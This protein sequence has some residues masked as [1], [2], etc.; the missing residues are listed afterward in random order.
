MAKKAVTSQREKLIERQNNG[1]FMVT[2]FTS[3]TSRDWLWTKRG[4]KV[5]DKIRAIQALSCSLPTKVNKTRGNP[6]LTVKRCKT[7][8][9]L[10]A[11]LVK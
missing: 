8:N 3:K 9:K 6:N 7:F 1:R 4:L 10:I 11:S 2:T 5:G